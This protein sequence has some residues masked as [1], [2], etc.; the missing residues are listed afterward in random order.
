M[1]GEEN[2]GETCARAAAHRAHA[3]MTHLRGWC[4]VAFACGVCRF[5]DV[6]FARQSLAGS[7]II[8][9]SVTGGQSVGVS[10][11]RFKKEKKNTIYAKIKVNKQQR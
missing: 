10:H 9:T 7:D 6:G 11:L 1:R 8:I 3:R 4:T 2:S 5:S